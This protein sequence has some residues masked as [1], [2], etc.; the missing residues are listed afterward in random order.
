MLLSTGDKITFFSHF[1]L[2]LKSV[3]SKGVS[4]FNGVRNSLTHYY[5]LVLYGTISILLFS[6]TD[7]KS[8]NC[9]LGKTFLSIL[10]TEF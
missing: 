5:P 6:H 8:R 3:W 1:R 2:E 9:F 4:G 7:L 10:T